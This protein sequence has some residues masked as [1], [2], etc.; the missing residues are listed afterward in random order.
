MPI[1]LDYYAATRVDDDVSAFWSSGGVC[2]APTIALRDEITR[3]KASGDWTKVKALTDK[4]WWA[5]TPMFPAGGF[6]EFS[7]YNIAIDKARMQAAGWMQVGPARPP[8][9]M[10]PDHIRDGAVTA[11]KRWAEL[12]E[13]TASIIA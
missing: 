8:Y 6:R 1:E 11:G 7:M 3:A 13:M 2:P 10:M 5:V 9:D 4:M 12:A